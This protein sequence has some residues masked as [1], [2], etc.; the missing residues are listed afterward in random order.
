ALLG[1]RGNADLVL[2][3]KPLGAMHG[4][5]AGSVLGDRVHLDARIES[6]D[7]LD[8]DAIVVATP[9]RESARL[10]EEEPPELEDSPIISV[11]LWFAERL[12]PTP[13]AALL[14]T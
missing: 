3:T 10:L 2:P 9:P 6:L 14:G 7:D 1:P 5:A 4:D 11:H 8:A 13:L 12:L